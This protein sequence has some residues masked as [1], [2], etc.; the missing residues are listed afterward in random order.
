MRSWVAPPR[1]PSRTLPARLALR[2]VTITYG[3]MRSDEL[4]LY[5][6]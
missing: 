6:G 3:N 5:Y 2:Q 4:L 1:R